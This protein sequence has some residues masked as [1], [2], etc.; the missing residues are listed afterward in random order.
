MHA[1]HRHARPAQA[2]QKEKLPP[3]RDPLLDHCWCDNH[4]PSV[5]RKILAEIQPMMELELLS[6]LVG[7]TP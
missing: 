3:M 1:S 5:E 2:V 7:R 4:E 6:L